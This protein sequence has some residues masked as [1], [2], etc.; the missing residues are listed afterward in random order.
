[1]HI[2][3]PTGDPGRVLNR[4]AA[5]TNECPAS[6]QTFG[7]PVTKRVAVGGRCIYSYSTIEALERPNTPDA[8]NLY[9]NRRTLSAIGV[10]M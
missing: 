2:C 1:M 3:G 9:N 10:G 8:S 6:L 5:W 7:F 4:V